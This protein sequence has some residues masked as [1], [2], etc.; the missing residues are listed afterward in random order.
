M[1][2]K[3]RLLVAL[4][5]QTILPA[6]FLLLGFNV[7]A[8]RTITGTV[9]GPD[10]K[11]VVGASVVVKGTTVGTTT[12]DQGVFSIAVPANR[13][14]L[15]IT[16]VEYE[17]NEVTITGNTVNVTMKEKDIT[18]NEVVV[19]GLWNSKTNQCYRCCFQCE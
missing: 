2:R 11:P 14:V 7:F 19:V 16:Y 12:N 17:V 6:F 5:K 9:T 18:Q 4:T 1:K 13:D 3:T 8:Q 10:S 15:I